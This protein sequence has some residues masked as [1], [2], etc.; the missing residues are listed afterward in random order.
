MVA[1]QLS[2]TSN[3]GGSDDLFVC[4]VVVIPFRDCEISVQI[5]SFRGVLSGKLTALKFENQ[6]VDGAVSTKETQIDDGLENAKVARETASDM[7]RCMDSEMDGVTAS[8]NLANKQQVL[9]QMDRTFKLEVSF[10]SS[11]QGAGEKRLLAKVFMTLPNS[12]QSSHDHRVSS[13]HGRH[14]RPRFGVEWSALQFG[15]PLFWQVALADVARAG[16]TA[17]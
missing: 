12:F 5:G 6:L 7:F 11:M 9:Q 1:D 17:H 8:S 2:V 10:L 15:Q 14:P 4:R 13:L 16:C 3:I